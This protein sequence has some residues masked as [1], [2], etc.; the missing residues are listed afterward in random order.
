MLKWGTPTCD[1][2]VNLDH[3]G[4]ALRSTGVRGPFDDSGEGAE[5]RYRESGIELLKVGRLRGNGTS[6]VEIGGETGGVHQLSRIC[7]WM[8]CLDALL[9]TM[10][11]LLLP[12]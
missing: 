11:G 9:F 10:T 4:S 5:A 12:C 1:G 2:G 7:C 8:M 6:V 3:G